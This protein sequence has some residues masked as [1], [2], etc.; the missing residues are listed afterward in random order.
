MPENIKLS[1]SLAVLASIDPASISP[2]SVNSSWVPATNF[3]SFLL[4]VQTGVLGAAATV[5]AKIQ[6]ATDVSGT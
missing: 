1:E 6:Q 2:G 3:L 5:D 4:V